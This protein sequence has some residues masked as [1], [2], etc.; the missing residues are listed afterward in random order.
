MAEPNPFHV[1]GLPPDAPVE[2]VK[3]AYRRAAR[4]LHPDAGGDEA[5]FRSLAR[6]AERAGAYARGELPNPYLDPTPAPYD[7][8]SH[9]AAPPPN[10]WRAGGLFWVLPVAASLF[11]L[12]AIAGPYFWLVFVASLAVLS[13]IVGWVTARR[14]SHSPRPRG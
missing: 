13:I 6:A 3:A 4:E 14:R 1:L 11:M 2:Q 8:H 9:A 10:V 7:R 12:S 5:A